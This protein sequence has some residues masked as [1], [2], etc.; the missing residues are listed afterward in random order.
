MKRFSVLV[1][2]LTLVGCAIAWSVQR[3][4]PHTL[5]PIHVRAQPSASLAALARPPHAGSIDARIFAA[6]G[7][8]VPDAFVWL[9]AGSE[10]HW[11][12]SE[13]PAGANAATVGTKE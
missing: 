4:M 12:Y 6:D 10:P 1:P 3:W 11:T 2:V 5:A 8:P 13:A 9:R 7:A